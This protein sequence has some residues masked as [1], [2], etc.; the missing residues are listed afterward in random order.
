MANI[1]ISYS[2]T[3]KTLVKI[4]AHIL[5]QKSWSV[6]WDR[7]IPIGENYDNVIERELNQADC[8]LV[9]WTKRSIQSEWVKNEASEAL[10]QKKLVPILLEQ[11]QI[12]LAFKRVESAL[13]IDWNG[14][15]NHPELELL[16]QAV[17]RILNGETTKLEE[18]R[19]E[20][21]EGDTTTAENI[22]RHVSSQKFKYIAVGICLLVASIGI[23][24]SALLVDGE[25][26]KQI[27]F[28]IQGKVKTSAEVPIE[29]VEVNIEGT[30]MAAKTS[31]DGSYRID[32]TELNENGE[33][34]ITTSHEGYADKT[35]KIKPEEQEEIEKDIYLNP[36]S[37]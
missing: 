12:P 33:I 7:D 23:L 24:R 1:F 20:N 29:Q 35:I 18:E 19:I 26:N 21:K 25:A 9:I 6:W 3:D 17:S 8:V 30:N 14:E 4:L 34:E 5:E 13:L 37:K 11:V 22:Q 31:S 16:F 32:V 36:I 27:H 2:S 10:N 15:G 28:I